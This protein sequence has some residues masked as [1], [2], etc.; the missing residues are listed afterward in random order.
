[1]TITAIRLLQEEFGAERFGT[2]YFAQ[3]Q[4][5]LPAPEPAARNLDMD[6]NLLSGKRPRGRRKNRYRRECDDREVL[7]L[8]AQAMDRLTVME[9]A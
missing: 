6:P 4:E 8:V 3:P 1:M 2:D 7:S 5:V 9:A